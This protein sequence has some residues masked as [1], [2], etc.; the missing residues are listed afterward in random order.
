M[1]FSKREKKG[2]CYPVLYQQ[3]CQEEDKQGDYYAPLGNL[4]PLQEYCD[5][6]EKMHC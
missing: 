1:L 6:F 4:S 2:E 3:N 5:P